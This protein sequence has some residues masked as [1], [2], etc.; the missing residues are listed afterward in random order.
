MNNPPNHS[1]PNVESINRQVALSVHSHRV[2]LRVLTT[3]AFAFGFLAIVI[4]LC[5]LW[6][7]RV[8]YWPKQEEMF[9]QAH[10]EMVALGSAADSKEQWSKQISGVLGTEVTL[11]A[12]LSVG[13][14]TVALSVGLLSLG[15]LVL[16]TVVL[17][18][19]RVTL[20]QLNSSLAQIS[21]Q[22]RELQKAHS[23]P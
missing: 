22:L 17:L 9:K 13:V 3:C 1:M 18:N 11:T 10:N 23:G 20:N 12:I 21:S 6:L 2:K 7:W 5:T 8:K 16:T 14:A 4:S 19:R 15:M